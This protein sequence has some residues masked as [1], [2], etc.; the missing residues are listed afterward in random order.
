MLEIIPFITWTVFNHRIGC[1]IILTGLLVELFFGGP[2]TG[3]LFYS[4]IF[5]CLC[6]VGILLGVWQR[7]PF[8]LN[9]EQAILVMFLIIFVGETFF[10]GPRHRFPALSQ[11]G[12]VIG[13]TLLGVIYAMISFGLAKPRQSKAVAQI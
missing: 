13:L 1:F 7:V 10:G 12:I 5:G 3:T 8:F 2:R 11:N 4:A 6:H 9:L